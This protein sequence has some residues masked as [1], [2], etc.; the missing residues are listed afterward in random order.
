MSYF[1]SKYLIHFG[2]KGQKWGVRRFQNEDGTLTEEG[3]KRYLQEYDKAEKEAEKEMINARSQLLDIETNGWNAKSAFDPGFVKQLKSEKMLN[4][5]NLEFFKNYFQEDLESAKLKKDAAQK[6]KSFIEQNKDV[7]LDDVL[8]NTRSIDKSNDTELSKKAEA[9]A[10]ELGLEK[11]KKKVSINLDIPDYD[12]ET[13]DFVHSNFTP[14]EI[15]DN[16]KDFRS[17]L[18][19]FGID[20]TKMYNSNTNQKFEDLPEDQQ[21]YIMYKILE[22]IYD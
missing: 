12:D 21:F 16:V 13:K 11:S 4:D 18:S 8:T 17:Q 5:E 1:N 10:K 6:A 19:V 2:I 3:K 14:K 7:T 20:V 9:V 15:K 22:K